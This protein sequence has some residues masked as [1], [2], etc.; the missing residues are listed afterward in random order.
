MIFL[1]IF[2]VIVLLTLTALFVN[3]HLIFI[4]REKE[5]VRLRVLC[6]SFDAIK[7]YNRYAE[8]KRKKQIPDPQKSSVE[9]KKE[10]KKRGFDPIGFAEFLIHITRVISLAVKESLESMKINLK[11]L[12]VSV[13]TDD[14]AKTALTAGAAIQ[15]ANGLCAALQYFSDF[16]CDNRKLSISPDFTSEK[17]RFSIHLDLC[18]KPI[19]LIGVLLRTYTRFFERKESTK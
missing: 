16:R 7:L 15:A 3:V 2:L 4:Y 13:G 14:A 6:F 8:K 17:S 19:H 9:T 12:V 10:I 1:Y 18:I 11:E 5:K